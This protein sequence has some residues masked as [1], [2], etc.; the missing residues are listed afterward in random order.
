MSV[1]AHAVSENVFSVHAIEQQRFDL[2]LWRQRHSL[3]HAA[4]VAEID[5]VKRV[6]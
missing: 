4:A 3:M 1:P 5:H 6:H 2:T